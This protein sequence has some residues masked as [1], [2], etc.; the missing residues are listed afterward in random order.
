[1]KVNVNIVYKVKGN[2]LVTSEGQGHTLH[3][4]VLICNAA[5]LQWYRW[6]K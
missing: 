6:D 4:A 5:I 1:M 3:A 2:Y